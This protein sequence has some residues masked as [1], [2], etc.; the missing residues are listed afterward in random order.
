VHPHDTPPTSSTRLPDGRLGTP[1]GRRALPDARRSLGR[2][3]EQLAAAHLQRLGFSVVA[4][5]VRTRH[6][7]IDL[8]A[9]DGATLLFAEV[10]TRRLSRPGA[11][12]QLEQDPLAA[13]GPRQRARLRRLAVAWLSNEGTARPTARTIR[14]DAVGVIVDATDR[15]V[16]LD[17]LEAA[18]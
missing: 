9:F 1:D 11:A 4:R 18:W 12:G 5:N 13:L 16:R 15:L 10:K 6:G 14:F 17:H 7:E 2:L 3:G 8:I